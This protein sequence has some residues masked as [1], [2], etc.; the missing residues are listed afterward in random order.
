MLISNDYLFSEVDGHI[1][2]LNCCYLET[3]HKSTLLS[4]HAFPVWRL[5]QWFTNSCLEFLVSHCLWDFASLFPDYSSLKYNFTPQL[6][7]FGDFW[8]AATNDLEYIG[9]VNSGK[10]AS[11]NQDIKKQNP[12]WHT[13]S[14]FFHIDYWEFWSS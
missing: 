10:H 4:K 5:K 13:I 7:F 8:N 9:F 11:I 6:I 12:R 3:V 14:T 2:V 1:Y